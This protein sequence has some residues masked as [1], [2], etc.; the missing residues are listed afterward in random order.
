MKH[1]IRKAHKITGLFS[2]VIL[3][4]S[5]L[6][7]TIL[8]FE[9]EIRNNATIEKKYIENTVGERLSYN[10]IITS[11]QKQQSSEKIK[12]IRFQNKNPYAGVKVF[13][14]SKKMFVLNPY[15]GLIIK[16]ASKENFM[17]FVLN[18]HRTLG[19]GDFGEFII[20]Y[21]TFLVLFLSLS[22]IY[23]WFPRRFKR[24]KEYFSIKTQPQKRFLF[25]SHRVIGIYC[26]FFLL[27]ICFTGINFSFPKFLSQL[28][29]G[30][31]Q[32]SENKKN[33]DT[34]QKY[35]IDYL[36][37]H[38]PVQQKCEELRII[39][40]NSQNSNLVIE[41]IVQ[42]YPNRLKNIWSF[43]SKTLVK[44][45]YKSYSEY[46]LS[47]KILSYNYAL[48]TGRI[49]GDISKIIELVW[50]IFLLIIPVTG[51]LMWRKKRNRKTTV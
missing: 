35:N 51:F 25:D 23:L 9:D 40:P 14:I 5:A 13:T 10:E 34:E 41:E 31:T 29:D 30:K 6:T 21:N 20:K 12:Q 3:L 18:I 44:N 17:D 24:I 36:V 27:I 16:E 1:L 8:L 49:W 39:F 4:I 38:N 48:H 7:G 42:K 32:V 2:M 28:L 46:T 33:K 15:N 50:V 22:G 47:D 19:M 45:S 11:F 37:S 43:D 26:S